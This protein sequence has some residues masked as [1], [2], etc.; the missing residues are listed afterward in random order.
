MGKVV[1]IVGGEECETVCVW[2]NGNMSCVVLWYFIIY[3]YCVVRQRLNFLAFIKNE[4]S[5][6]SHLLL[7]KYQ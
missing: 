2:R 7:H 6:F 1:V 5:S 4:C 3:I